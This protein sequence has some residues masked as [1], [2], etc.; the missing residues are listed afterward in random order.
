MS[1]HP[2]QT[3]TPDDGS[4]SL[5]WRSDGP[6]FAFAFLSV[7]PGWES[8]SVVL[9]YRSKPASFVRCIIASLSNFPKSTARFAKRP[10]EKSVDAHH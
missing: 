3:G 7:I 8:A 2:E 10:Q 1:C 6:A 4:L 5:G 9:L